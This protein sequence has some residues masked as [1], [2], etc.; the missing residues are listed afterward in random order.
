[1]TYTGRIQDYKPTPE[2]EE[3]IA[4]HDAERAELVARVIKAHADKKAEVLKKVSET[5]R[6]APV[7]RKV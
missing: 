2:Q 7:K 4:K 3:A 6:K 1:M 5:K